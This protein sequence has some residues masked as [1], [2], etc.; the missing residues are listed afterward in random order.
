MIKEVRIQLSEWEFNRYNDWVK[1]YF[2]TLIRP[3][4]FRDI[5]GQAYVLHHG[6]NEG[7]LIGGYSLKDLR[8]E[9]ANNSNLRE[10]ESI[11]LICCHSA[12]LKE[13]ADDVEVYEKVRSPFPILIAAEE[14]THSAL[15]GVLESRDDI[16]ELLKIMSA[17]GYT[18]AEEELLPKAGGK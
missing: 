10:D 7:H 8:E 13:K 17:A 1:N 18:V 2:M 6:S 5:N 14:E 11:T 15:F 4:M 9:V 16:P 12:L 3:F